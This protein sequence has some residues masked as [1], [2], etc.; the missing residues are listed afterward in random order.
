MLVTRR[1][2]LT[3]AVIVVFVSVLERDGGPNELD[4]R[5]MLPIY[6]RNSK[7]EPGVD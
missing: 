7:S 6:G 5:N 4:F 3:V 1:I 2:A